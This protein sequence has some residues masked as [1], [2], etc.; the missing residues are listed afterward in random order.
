M[1]G[2]EGSERYAACSVVCCR[3]KEINKKIRREREARGA[4]G[5]RGI[6]INSESPIRIY[7][8]LRSPRYFHMFRNPFA[9][10]NNEK[11]KEGEGTA[12]PNKCYLISRNLFSY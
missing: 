1:E 11:N 5:L 3:Y 2:C 12:H 4:R 7:I 8:F 6:R 10:V 9:Q